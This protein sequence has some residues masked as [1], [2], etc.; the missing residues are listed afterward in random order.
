[1]CRVAIH[2]TRLPRATSSLAFNA[3]LGHL[4]VDVAVG[5]ICL[6]VRVLTSSDVSEMRVAAAFYP[7]ALLSH[8]PTE[9]SP[10]RN[11]QPV[12]PELRWVLVM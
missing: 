5:F 7:T 9:F 2:Q 4:E 12:T 10:C 3:Y 1:M 8:F 6:R 11:A